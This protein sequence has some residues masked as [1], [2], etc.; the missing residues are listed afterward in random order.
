LRRGWSSRRAATLSAVVALVAC[1][2]LSLTTTAAI[3]LDSHCEASPGGRGPVSAAAVNAS[4]KCYLAFGFATSQT[5]SSETAAQAGCAQDPAQFLNALASGLQPLATSG[6]Q[7]VAATAT[8]KTTYFSAEQSWYAERRKNGVVSLLG[9]I[10]T[11]IATVKEQDTAF[12]SDL[13]LLAAEWSA[14]DCGAAQNA[15]NRATTD[16]AQT[17]SAHASIVGLLSQLDDCVNG[18][19]KRRKTACR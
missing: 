15:L 19:A 1:A 3:G 4:I 6:E 5:L 13:G 11:Q 9:R 16:Q 7:D 10:V 8:A 2:G 17:G 14:L 12:Y 18:S